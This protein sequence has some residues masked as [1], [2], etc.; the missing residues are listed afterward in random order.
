MGQVDHWVRLA[1]AAALVVGGLLIGSLGWL[2][3]VM[4]VAAVVLV[5]T[6]TLNFC[7]IYWML[8]IRTCPRE[9]AD[10]RDLVGYEARH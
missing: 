6:A 5:G 10:P 9:M 4:Y 1:L 2:P 8:G 3:V 7:P